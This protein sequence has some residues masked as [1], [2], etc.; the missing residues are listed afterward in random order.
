MSQSWAHK[1]EPM[2]RGILLAVLL[3]GNLA[4]LCCAQAPPEKLSSMSI[5]DLLNVEVT[6][7]SKT[8]QKISDTAAAIYVI[9]QEDIQRSGATN[10]PDLLRMVPGMDV[11]QINSNTWAISARGFNGRYADDLMVLLDGRSIYSPTFGGVYWDALDLPMEDIDRIEVIRGPGGSIWGANAVNGVVNI[12][13]KKASET[14]GAMVVAG[15]GSLTPGFGTVQYGGSA[16]KTTDYRVYSKYFSENQLPG[17]TAA[18][19]GDGW[20]DPR[21]G[22]RVDSTVSAKDKLTFQGDVYRGTEDQF[23]K[24]LPSIGSSIQSVE[25]SMD[26]SGGFFQGIWNH[27]L[28]A[29]SASAL[30]ISYDRY[31]H[32]NLVNEGEGAFLNLDFQHQYRWKERQNLVWGMSVYDSAVT[33]NGGLAVS[34]NP[35]DVTVRQFGAFARG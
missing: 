3:S 16:G 33:T 11:A 1:A 29:R 2:R 32:G 34:F 5:E 13:T 4:S 30:E 24:F 25:L 15:A 10:I 21:G 9:T 20:D 23:A 26:L 7:V 27:E 8:Q 12:I 14:K 6:S 18:D 28:S 19:G 22:F 35:P 31:Q 17:I